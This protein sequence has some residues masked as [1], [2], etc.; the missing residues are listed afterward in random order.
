MLVLELG[1][2]EQISNRFAGRLGNVGKDALVVV[3]NHPAFPKRA[4][5]QEPVGCVAFDA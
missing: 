5:S 1:Q 3:R 4:K 2:T